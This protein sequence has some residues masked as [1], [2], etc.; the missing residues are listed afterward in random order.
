MTSQSCD[1]IKK[2][3]EVSLLRPID[4]KLQKYNKTV[5]FFI[6][7]FCFWIFRHGANAIY[8]INS[9]KRLHQSFRLKKNS[10]GLPSVLR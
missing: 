3:F 9:L 6:S 1:D 4:M 2:L 7:S 10:I 8:E 5:L